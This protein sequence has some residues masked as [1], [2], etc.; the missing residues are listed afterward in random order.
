MRG[1]AEPAYV[2]ALDKKTGKEVWKKDRKTGAQMECKHSYT[3]PVC[4][5]TASSGSC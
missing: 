5:T 2:V 1:A 3:S 4:M